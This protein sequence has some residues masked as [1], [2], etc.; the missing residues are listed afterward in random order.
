MAYRSP[1]FGPD[2]QGMFPAFTPIRYFVLTARRKTLGVFLNDNLDGPG[3]IQFRDGMVYVSN[4]T[5]HTVAR[6]AATTGAFIDNFV[7]AGAGGLSRPND[8]E[9]GSNGNLYV[10]GWDNFS[11]LRYDGMTGQFIDVYAAQ[12]EGGL[13]PNVPFI[14]FGNDG[15]LYIANDYANN[16]LR[17]G[18]AGAVFEVSLTEASETPITVDYSTADG[19]ALSG[20]DYSIA[21]GTVT[22]APGQTMQR[23]VVP[24]VDDMVAEPNKFFSVNL[25]N[26][27]GAGVT[28]DDGHG[29]ATIIDDEALRHISIGD[30][31]V[32]EGGT[33]AHYYRGA[34][35]D[36]LMEE[37]T[38]MTT[39][40]RMDTCMRL[41]AQCESHQSLRC[42]HWC[43]H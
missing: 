9:F 16:V 2:R 14:T 41:Q 20:S 4:S 8:M 25:S 5:I 15:L 32:N 34:F 38:S 11:I 29:I 7:A 42:G 35:V 31:T 12:G 19:S 24:L 30:V 37:L 13:G 22:F 3:A 36:A 18:K 40:L 27:T 17:F 28:I 43:F 1:V 26:A 39:H 6:F 10:M 21:T 23:I 33:A